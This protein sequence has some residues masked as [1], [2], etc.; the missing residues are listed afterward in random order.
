MAGTNDI[1]YVLI[2]FHSRDVFDTLS[3]LS[4]GT[5]FSLFCAR[6]A[7]HYLAV[8]LRSARQIRPATLQPKTHLF[9]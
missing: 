8:L 1:V 5:C 3:C 9:Y 6:L 7:V 2:S 4:L